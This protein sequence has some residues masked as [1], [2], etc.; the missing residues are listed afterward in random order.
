MN[1]G[2]VVLLQGV[3]G[4][5]AHGLATDSSDT[6]RH[7][8]YALPTRHVLG[9]RKM[10]WSRRTDQDTIMWE[11][12]N[13]IRLA[14]SSNPAVL[15]LL[16]LPRYE[17]YTGLGEQLVA[18]RGSLITRELVRRSYMLNADSQ[19]AKM[20]HSMWAMSKMGWRGDR[21][22][23]DRKIRKRARSVA[24][25]LVQGME[26]WETGN[27]TVA[28]SPER[29]TSVRAAEQD[30]VHLGGLLDRAD[31]HMQQ[32]QSPLREEPDLKAAEKWLLKVRAQNWSTE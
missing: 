25:T 31:E 23:A 2:N 14:L 4:S 27:I 13:A 10:E 9:L 29:I 30:P 5:R 20:R 21:E 16:F 24:I 12:G 26:L 3:T 28:L 1:D 11:A 8:I 17:T 32:V 15:E 18:L 6:D 7:G 22:A 19:A